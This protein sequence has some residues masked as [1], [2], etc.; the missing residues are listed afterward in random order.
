M[1]VKTKGIVLK[2]LKYSETS[3][4]LDIYTEEI[5]LRSCIVNGVRKA[6]SKTASLY[7]VLQILD[8]VIYDKDPRKLN[9]IKEASSAY[10]Y[11][12]ITLDIH[13]TNLAI[14][15]IDIVSNTIKEH[16]ENTDLFS[17][18][19]MY[20]R[21]VDKTMDSIALLSL[22][23]MLDLSSFLGFA[24]LDNYGLHDVYFD[25]EEG[26]FVSDN[27][28]GNYILPLEL[29]QHIRTVLNME[30]QDVQNYSVPKAERTILLDKMILYYKLHLTGFKDPKSLEIF[31]RL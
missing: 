15:I 1:L 3:L 7:Q 8:L 29:S 6:K 9:R 16:E 5:G 13:K 2:S 22:K 18:I 19:E 30:M 31:R 28:R 26:K 27:K 12:S 23:F 11:Q 24:P 17:F 25:L 14:F 21:Y 4:I 20:L 10:L